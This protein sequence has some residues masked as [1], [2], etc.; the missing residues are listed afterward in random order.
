MTTRIS[1]E[2]ISYVLISWFSMEPPEIKYLK[3]HVGTDQIRRVVKNIREEILDLGG[4][5]YFDSRLTDTK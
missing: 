5:T 3:P 1:D 4:E 2:R